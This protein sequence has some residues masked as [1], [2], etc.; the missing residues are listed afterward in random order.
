MATIASDTEYN[1]DGTVKTQYYYDS[2]DED[3]LKQAFE[4]IA[5]SITVNNDPVSMETQD[6]KITLTSGFEVGQNVEFYYTENYN[7]DNVEGS[8]PYETISWNEFI[9]KSYVEYN[10]TEGTL[11]LDLGAYM[12]SKSMEPNEEITI[13]F[14]RDI[15][16]QTRI[17]PA[18]ILSLAI[19]GIE[20]E[21]INEETVSTYEEK[22]NETE[23]NKDIEITKPA[24][25]NKTE[26]VE[27]TKPDNEA[28]NVEDNTENTTEGEN[29]TEEPTIDKEEPAADQEETT[30]TPTVEEKP[31]AAVEEPITGTTTE[32]ENTVEETTSNINEENIQ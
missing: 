3:S 6:G 25:T 7:S 2:Y 10:E 21:T 13:R 24:D 15:T 30:N 23:A 18:N 20:D 32:T 29:I 8:T 27:T 1:T 11:S 17:A 5:T 26:N 28:G 19:T 4:S 9:D 16:V 31:E 22:I 12:E 14:V